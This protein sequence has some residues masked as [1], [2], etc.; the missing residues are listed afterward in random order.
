MGNFRNKLIAIIIVTV[1]VFIIMV[2]AITGKG[3]SPFLSNAAETVLL[4]V[5]KLFY[6]IGDGISSFSEYFYIKKQLAAENEEL[7][8]QVSDLEKQ[9]RQANEYKIENNRLL[10]MLNM[11][12]A[13]K[14]FDLCAA[15]VVAKESLNYFD[16]FIID[17]GTSD[18]LAKYMPVVNTQGLVG[19]ISEIGVNW[20]KVVSIIDSSSS[21]GAYVYRTS[22]LAVVEGDAS[23]QIDGNCKLV[24][25][26]K[27]T[28]VMAGDSIETSG[29]GGIYPKGLLIGTVDEVIIDVNNVS[30]SAVVKPAVNFKK[31]Q[32]VFVITNAETININQ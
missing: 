17:K 4:P 11:K 13:R 18:G 6:N 21:M 19:H 3:N 10:D 20:A 30:Q 29:L 16:V 31:L 9:V 23:L 22:E 32:E 15:K 28:G 12:N 1:L 25:L 26:N 7:K 8:K 27:D 2:V 5:Q 24:Y 14:E